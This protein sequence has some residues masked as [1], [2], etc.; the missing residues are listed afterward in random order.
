MCF[1]VDKSKKPTVMNNNHNHNNSKS[2]SV[3]I[4]HNSAQQS[5]SNNNSHSAA[6]RTDDSVLSFPSAETPISIHHA[7]MKPSKSRNTTTSD[8]PSKPSNQAGKSLKLKASKP[9]ETKE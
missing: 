6:H 5:H 2:N 9:V 1:T 4:Y 7:K 3:G 8:K